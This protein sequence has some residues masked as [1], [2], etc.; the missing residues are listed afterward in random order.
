MPQ[1]TVKVDVD[2]VILGIR[3]GAAYD[4][5]VDEHIVETPFPLN[6]DSMFSKDDHPVPLTKLVA[7]SIILRTQAELDADPLTPRNVLIQKVRAMDYEEVVLRIARAIRDLGE[8]ME[9]AGLDLSDRPAYL[10]LKNFL[11]TLE[12]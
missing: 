8:E 7:G 5:G 9:A 2:N 6:V 10:Q 3:A 11:D 4:L 1:Y 12:T